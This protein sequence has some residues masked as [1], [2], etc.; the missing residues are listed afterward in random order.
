MK[1]TLFFATIFALASA[2]P[3]SAAP[4][5]A[6]QSHQSGGEEH[7]VIFDSA[8]PI[9]LR[10][11]DILQSLS[12]SVGHPDVTHV[13]NNS[14]FRGFSASMKSH[15]L[16]LL[17]NTPGIAVVEKSV[18]VASTARPSSARPER[19]DSA[20]AAGS[21]AVNYRQNAPWG[22]QRISSASSVSGDAS[23][24]DYTYSYQSNALG[25]GADIYV[26]DTGIYT[27]HSVFGGRARMGWSYEPD[28]SDEDGHGTHVAGTA[29]G[30]VFGVASAANIIGVKALAG[31]GSGLSS[32]VI[33]GIDWVVQQHDARMGQAGFVGSVM[34]MSLESSSPVPSINQAI[35]AA[36]QAGI[37]SCVAAGN[38]AT[39]ACRSSPASTGGTHGP[40]IA[41][42]AVTIDSAIAPFSNTGACVDVYAPGMAILSAWVGAPYTVNLLDG[43]SMATPHV[44]GLVACAIAANATLAGSV[45]L[46]KRWVVEAALGGVVA[47]RGGAG[48]DRP[49]LAN[50]GVT[51]ASMAGIMGATKGQANYTAVVVG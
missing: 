26:I 21:T 37:H 50:N 5:Q 17:Q 33:A 42:G 3:A 4:L 11:H 47:P 35:T 39:D 15:C 22:L 18:Q 49:L 44:T 20:L 34:S 10:V 23:R 13:Y 27:A 7:V 48:G 36:T 9:P 43:T 24:L 45:S 41:V 29:A 51:G 46:M 30:S 14:V 25:A 6:R 1:I 2:L 8:H 12:L 31:D 40:S 38:S 19:R 28:S 16:D 32:N